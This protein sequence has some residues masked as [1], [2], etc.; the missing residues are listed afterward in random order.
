MGV[1]IQPDR[2]VRAGSRTAHA[3][4][5]KGKETLTLALR[6]DLRE[7]LARATRAMQSKPGQSDVIRDETMHDVVHLLVAHLGS[8]P[9]DVQYRGR[10]LS[11]TEYAEQIVG[12]RPTEWRVVVS[13]PL[14][15]FHHVY[16][17]RG[18]AS[19]ATPAVQPAPPQPAQR[20]L[21]TLYA[22]R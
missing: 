1:G 6:V 2:E 3:R 15:S 16:E 10:T 14:L 22:G 12:F 18:S 19:P 11:P 9:S 7:C 20:R 4:D 5:V 8:P 13:N 17:R 21:R